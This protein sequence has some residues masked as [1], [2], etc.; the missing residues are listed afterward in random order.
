MLIDD[1]A[2]SLKNIEPDIQ[3]IISFCT[4]TQL[5]K[6]FHDLESLLFQ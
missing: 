4:N 3:T 5:E 2:E 6:K 1:L